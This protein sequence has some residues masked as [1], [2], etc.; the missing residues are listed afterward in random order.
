MLGQ[1]LRRQGGL[2]LPHGRLRV[3][4][5]L[6]RRAPRMRPKGLTAIRALG[7]GVRSD[8]RLRW[9]APL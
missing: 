1:G 7:G 5:A 2:R 4:G 8:A 9:R 3:G 6:P